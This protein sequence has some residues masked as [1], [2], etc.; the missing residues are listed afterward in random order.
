MKIFFFAA[1]ST[2]TRD[3]R[4]EMEE[5]VNASPLSMETVARRREKTDLENMVDEWL[6]GPVVCGLWLAGSR[7]LFSLDFHLDLYVRAGHNMNLV[8]GIFPSPPHCLFASRKPCDA[9]HIPFSFMTM[10]MKQTTS[11][12]LAFI[13]L[14]A[15]LDV[16][17]FSPSSP[18]TS[19]A[20]ARWMPS[21]SSSPLHIHKSRHNTLFAT[22]NEL[23]FADAIA[24]Q[25]STSVNDITSQT[26]SK[27]SEGRRALGSQELL[28][29]P[30]QYRPKLNEGLPPFPSMSH[31]QVTVLSSTPSVDA[32]SK[33]IDIAMDTHPMLRC[34][35]EGDGEP[36]ERIDLFQMVRKGEPN[37]CTFVAPETTP[38]T[39]K[40]VLRVVD[41]SGS[42]MASL[43]ASWKTNFAKDIDDGSWYEIS[44]KGPLWRMT[45]HRLGDGGDDSPCALVFSANHAIS[46][47]GSVN[48]LMDQL[49]ADIVSIEHSGKVSNKAVVQEVPMAMEDSVLGTN[50]RWSDVHTSGLSPGT[51]KYVLDKAAEGLKSPVILPDSNGNAGGG[52]SVLGA[53]STIMGKSAG[54]ESEASSERKTVLQ[55][56]SLPTETTSAL[57]EA[58]RANG[59]SITNALIAATTLAS[60]DFIDGGDSKPG[61]ER[62]YKVLQSLDMRRFGAQLDKCDTV[63]CMAGSN[64]LMFGPLKD[65]SGEVFCNLPESSDSQDMF[66]GL[67]KEGRDQTKQFVDSNGPVHAVRVFDFA[68]TISD[69]NNL[70]DLTVKSKDSQGRAYSAGLSNVG[71]YERQKAVKRENGGERENIQVSMS[72]IPQQ[73]LDFA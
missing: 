71:V 37:P 65:N 50:N 31:V 14:C 33:A 26:V 68:M 12:A 57:L 39:S 10:S 73:G 49:L 51:V 48:V 40:D 5:Y 58:C 46:D 60:T 67:A 17:A 52:D 35:V 32:I 69:M 43:E 20:S 16:E 22:S 38:F 27:K 24:Q 1:S 70:V 13:W 34:H 6:W 56:R 28:M 29:L 42:D 19:S 64:D 55:F 53:V 54:G 62:N 63:A 18:T 61:K 36:D 21:S 15:I 8:E 45:M 25:E 2:L 47:Q 3:E 23:F 11:N 41:V 30:R 66:W 72:C 59:V 7:L 44:S 9:W 4:R